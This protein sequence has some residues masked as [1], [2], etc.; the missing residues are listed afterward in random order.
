LPSIV[1]GTN[2]GPGEN[3]YEE[4]IW[5]WKKKKKNKMKCR[6]I[7]NYRQCPQCLSI[8]KKNPEAMPGKWA[9]SQ[10][11]CLCTGSIRFPVAIAPA[12][13]CKRRRNEMHNSLSLCIA[14]RCK[15]VHGTEVAAK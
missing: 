4:V 12:D 2:G 1:Y 10:K 7:F 13:I 3:I 6:V 9:N 15:L 5:T 11:L 14:E 8:D